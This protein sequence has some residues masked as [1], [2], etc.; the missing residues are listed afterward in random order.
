LRCYLGYWDVSDALQSVCYWLATWQAFK[1]GKRLDYMALRKRLIR[2]PLPED[3]VLLTMTEVSEGRAAE[4]KTHQR[5]LV[6]VISLYMP[7]YVDTIAVIFVII[8]VIAEDSDDVQFNRLL[9]HTASGHQSPSISDRKA[10]GTRC[11][12]H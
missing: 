8:Y 7:I 1:E 2:L 9:V 6:T 10:R 4:A 11:T 3:A 5:I 12:H